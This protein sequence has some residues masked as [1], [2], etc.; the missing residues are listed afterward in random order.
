[1][2]VQLSHVP[3][4]VLAGGLGTRVQHLLPDL[5]K[6]MA[7]VAGRPFLEWVVRYLAR[8]GVAQVILSSGYRAEVIAAHF[9]RQP[10]RGVHVQCV[11]ET[12]PLGTAGGFLHA[13]E[14][15]G[16]DADAWLVLNGDSL[17]FASLDAVVR[18]LDDA[19]CAGAIVA[20]SVPDASRYGSIVADS[21]GRI[22]GFEEKR[23]GPGLI[24]AGVYLLR[25]DLPARLPAGRPLSFEREVFPA[26]TAAG[27]LLRVHR[28]NAA[29]LDIGT[30]ES[31]P[32]A[33]EFIR[34]NLGQFSDV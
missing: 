7:P 20:R 1:M 16:R 11:A 17:V 18:E 2:S 27:S 25:G 5:P 8:Q 31:L 30:A 19:D 6:P 4:V 22:L 34:G 12:G 24:N 3:A 32:Q 10:V 14:A 23:P 28:T 33:D 9:D 21:D 13:V 15:G 26:L 29:F